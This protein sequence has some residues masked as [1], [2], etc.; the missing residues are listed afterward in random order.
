[1]LQE[2]NYLYS[3]EP[4]PGEPRLACFKPGLVAYNTSVTEGHLKNLQVLKPY[5]GD[6]FLDFVED[7]TVNNVYTN[8]LADLYMH[9]LDQMTERNLHKHAWHIFITVPAIWSARARDNAEDRE[10]S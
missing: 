8:Y 3:D 1:M 9:L 6:N 2:M 5:L 4:E 10:R 7:G